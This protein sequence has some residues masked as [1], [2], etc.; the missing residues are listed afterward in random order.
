MGYK[1]QFIT[2][3]GFHAQNYAIFDLA[4]QYKKEGML[5][6]SRLQQ[7]E[8]DAETIGYTAAKHQR[9]VGASYFDEI[10]NIV[11]SGSSSTT[12]LKGSTEDEQFFDASKQ[13]IKKAS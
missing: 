9:E 13:S 12:A 11:S 6:Y 3:A 10:A 1:F 5:A 7:K 4:K 2:L 8:F